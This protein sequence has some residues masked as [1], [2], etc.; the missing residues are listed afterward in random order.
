MIVYF[1]LH[2]FDEGE[3]VK[4]YLPV[5][6]EVI[7]KINCNCQTFHSPHAH[8]LWH[9][10]KCFQHEVKM[11]SA[12]KKKS[13]Q[14]YSSDSAWRVIRLIFS[15]ATVDI[16]H[17]WKGLS[18]YIMNSCGKALVKLNVVQM[19]QGTVNIVNLCLHQHMLIEWDYLHMGIKKIIKMSLFLDDQ[20][21]VEK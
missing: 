9:K 20:W 16:D 2:T 21:F 12:Y 5:D 3:G 15:M 4:I 10:K 1:I 8:M 7:L 11:Q 19:Q 17:H 14:H 18:L 6:C 13:T